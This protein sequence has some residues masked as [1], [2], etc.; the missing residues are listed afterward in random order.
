MELDVVSLRE[1]LTTN[2]PRAIASSGRNMEVVTTTWGEGRPNRGRS[3]Q[4]ALLARA[5]SLRVLQRP[6]L[7]GYI[8]ERGQRLLYIRNVSLQIIEKLGP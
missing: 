5:P 7:M 3:D 4:S 8:L 6:T 2:N 1:Q